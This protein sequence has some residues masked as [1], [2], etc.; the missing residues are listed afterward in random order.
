MTVPRRSLI[1]GVATFAGALAIALFFHELAREFAD[2]A[3]RAALDREGPELGA[4]AFWCAPLAL[5]VA[6]IASR[7][8]GVHAWRGAGRAARRDRR[9]AVRVGR[10]RRQHGSPRVSVPGVLDVDVCRG[11]RAPPRVDAVAARGAR[12][13]GDSRRR[14]GGV[15]R[16]RGPGRAP[17]TGDVRRRIP[18]GNDCEAGPGIRT[19]SARAPDGARVRLPAGRDPAGRGGGRP[20]GRLPRGEGERGHRGAL[21]PVHGAQQTRPARRHGGAG[22]RRSWRRRAGSRPLPRRGLDIYGGEIDRLMRDEAG[23]SISD[24]T[25]RDRADRRGHRRYR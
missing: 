22:A 2:S 18:T 24:S 12:A 10:A 11:P 25:H 7:G 16:R 13:V 6:W 4:F 3:V 19:D 23:P 21:R 1:A 9:R 14:R 15:D 20:R 5:L 8:K 17:P